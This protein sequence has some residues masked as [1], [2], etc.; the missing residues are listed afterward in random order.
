MTKIH[1]SCIFGLHSQLLAHSSQIPLNFLS[2]K[3]YLCL[4]FIKIELKENNLNFFKKQSS[5]QMTVCLV[6]T[7]TE[8]LQ[9]RQK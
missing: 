8:S 4:L 2:D 5:H 9:S 1:F 6:P 7:R 3:I